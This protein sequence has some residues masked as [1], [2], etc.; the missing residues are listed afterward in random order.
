MAQLVQQSK[1]EQQLLVLILSILEVKQL[2]QRVYILMLQ[3]PTLGLLQARQ[4]WNVMESW[5]D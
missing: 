4:I 2:E 5:I 1:V 3:L